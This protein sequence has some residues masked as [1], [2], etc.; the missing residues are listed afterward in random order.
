[1]KKYYFF[2]FLL[3]LIPVSAILLMSASAGRN[4]SYSGSPGDGG[5]TCTQC[6]SG[7][8]FNASLA[9]QTE[10]PPEGYELGATYSLNVEITS[11]S[12]SKHG[13][14]ITAEK[15]SDGTK[16]G[17]FIADGSSN[18]L[19]NG[20]THVTHTATGNSQKIWN[21]NWK[22]P[23]TDVGEIKFYVS[24]LAGNGSGAGGDQVVTTTSTTF[25]VLG[26]SEAKRLNFKMYPNPASERIT[27][28][29]PSGSNKAAVQ[30]YDYLGRLALEKTISSR[31]NNNNN[32]IDVNNLSKGVYILKVL[33]DDKVGSQKFIKK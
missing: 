5:N 9:L 1:M 24:G 20:G 31:D 32:N 2:K 15:V 21:F 3:L 22:A 25:N 12:N 16:I 28:Q 4:G 17:T 8:S 30:F 19:K 14:Q 7:G 10:V 18:Q 11:T 29:L 23:T 27:I 26:V 13:F 33:T 6:H